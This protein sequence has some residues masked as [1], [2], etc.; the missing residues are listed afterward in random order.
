MDYTT[1]KNS[2]STLLIQPGCNRGIL[3][4]MMEQVL[5]M[6]ELDIEKDEVSKLLYDS[7]D[8]YVEILGLLSQNLRLEAIKRVR[9]LTGRDLNQAKKFID[10]IDYAGKVRPLHRVDDK[11]ST[12]VVEFYAELN[13][14][15]TFSR[16]NAINYVV[17]NSRM[18][19]GKA[20]D[21]VDAFTK[22]I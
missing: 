6:E 10:A 18:G 15:L 16:T 7:Q 9:E 5:K 12:D 22:G 2:I 21:F 3:D 11:F 13:R 14:A 4:N 20:A 1:L 17:L 8:F 19:Y